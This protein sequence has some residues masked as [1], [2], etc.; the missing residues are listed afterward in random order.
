MHVN[1]ENTVLLSDKMNECKSMSF[2]YNDKLYI[3]D[4]LTYYR[5]D[6]ENLI[7]VADK[8]RVNEQVLKIDAEH[9]ESS[10]DIPFIPT[11]SISRLP[12]GG[13]ESY[14]GVNV[15]YGF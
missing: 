13:G 3:N 14:Q 10:F 12:D 1:L 7:E 15:L 6:G 8:E 9:P 5:F 4:G 2:M 11:T